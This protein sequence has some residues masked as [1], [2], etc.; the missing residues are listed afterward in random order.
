MLAP[1]LVPCG[2]PDA[3]AAAL[4]SGA[5][6]LVFGL[7]EGGAFGDRAARR[8]LVLAALAAARARAERARLVVRV[9]A[10]PTG[11][12]DADLDAVMAGAPDAVMLPGAAGAADVQHLAAKLAVRE[13]EHGLAAG[14]TAVIAS[15]DTAMGVLALPTMPGA[16][17]RLLALGWDAA[18]LAADV[19]AKGERAQPC[20]SARGLLLIAAA[21]AGV[22]AIDAPSRKGGAALA[23]ECDAAR[24]DGFSGKLALH[25]NQVPV[26]LDRFAPKQVLGNLLTF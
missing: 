3:F 20:R 6:A 16:S 14:R 2:A 12:V 7:G 10:L 1:L 23:R 13:A 22:P 21:A 5:D 15:V 24:R 17:S 18:A 8:R 11:L 19:G 25:P 9:A 26:I 4:P